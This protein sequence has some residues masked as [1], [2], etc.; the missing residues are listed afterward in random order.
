MQSIFNSIPIAQPGH[1]HYREGWIN[2]HCPYCKGNKNFHL[3]YNIQGKYFYCWRC[4]F[5]PTLQTFEI[6]LGLPKNE[7]IQLLNEIDIP[8][9]KVNKV[10]NEFQLPSPLLPQLSQVH[11]KYLETRGF[12]S[13]EIER[14]WRVK[15]TGV[16]AKLGGVIYNH[17]IIIPIY[18]DGE[19]VNFQARDITGKATQKYMACPD[20]YAQIHIK[21]TVYGNQK[22]WTSMG[23]GVEGVFDVWR[24]GYSAVGFYGVNFKPAQVRMIA[25]NFRRFFILFD[26]DDAGQLQAERLKKELSFRGVDVYNY[27]LPGSKDPAELTA[28][29]GIQLVR[30]L[31]TW[32]IK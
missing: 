19:I 11:R 30:D 3:G 25:K 6:I 2:I 14:L 26:S 15:G 7:I 32:K 18:W 5:H 9:Q 17:R 28:E 8:I 21:R 12:D 23:I 31:K 27:I 16:V 22:E 20:S 10:K 1:K 13:Y 24:L 29:Q 4:G